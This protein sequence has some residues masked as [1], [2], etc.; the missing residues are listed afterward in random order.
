MN[1]ICQKDFIL[2]CVLL[3]RV[4][5]TPAA[6]LN[7]TPTTKWTLY[8]GLNDP[9]SSTPILQVDQALKVLNGIATKWIDG[10]TVFVAQGMYDMQVEDTLVYILLN[11]TEI[12][13][14]KLATEMIDTLR[15][16]TVLIEKADVWLSPLMRRKPTTSITFHGRWSA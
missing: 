11:T 6:A 4:V 15:Q 3:L 8:V 13:V 14:M 2:C 10:Y 7:F 9:I 1:W 16:D 12:Q 5:L